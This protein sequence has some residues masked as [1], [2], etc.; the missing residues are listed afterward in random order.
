MLTRFFVL[1]NAP[2]PRNEVWIPFPL[3]GL[4]RAELDW[5][6]VAALLES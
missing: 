2:M 3:A 4:G 1:E 5:L 6:A